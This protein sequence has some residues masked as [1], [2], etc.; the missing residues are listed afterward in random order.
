[1]ELKDAFC[2]VEKVWVLSELQASYNAKLP[3]VYQAKF[4]QSYWS[5][6]VEVEV[7]TR[8]DPEPSTKD[9]I[10]P[11]R[12][13]EYIESSGVGES[14]VDRGSTGEGAYWPMLT[15]RLL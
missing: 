14:W 8:G 7:I 4:E 10:E 11:T 6:Y 12:N 5:G 3:G 13:S 9:A 15:S 2:E 1:M